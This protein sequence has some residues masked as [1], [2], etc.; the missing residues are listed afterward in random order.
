MNFNQKTGPNIHKKLL[1]KSNFWGALRKEAIFT[2]PIV[3]WKPYITYLFALLK[4]KCD[5][6][7]TKKGTAKEP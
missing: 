6:R 1:F 5:R 3:S 7:V 4:I 2:Y